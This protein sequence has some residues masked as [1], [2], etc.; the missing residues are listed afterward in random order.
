MHDPARTPDNHPPPRG[1][2]CLPA[3]LDAPGP[4]AVLQHPTLKAHHKLLWL[5]LATAA[6]ESGATL[7]ADI[8]ASAA[9]L[10]TR[11]GENDRNVRRWLADLV[12]AGLVEL[13]DRQPGRNSHLVV[14]DPV[15][16][17]PGWQVRTPDPQLELFDGQGPEPTDSEPSGLRLAGLT[18]S[19]RSFL[20]P[21]MTG[22][23]TDLVPKMTGG[24]DAHSSISAH[25]PFLVVV[26][27]LN[28]NNNEAFIRSHHGE[29]LDLAI[30][31]QKTIL[32]K[33]RPPDRSDRELLIRCAYLAM[34]HWGEHWLRAAARAR[35][36]DKPPREPLAFFRAAAA[37]HAYEH[38]TCE[39]AEGK[40]DR[41]A[42]K[43]GFADVLRQIKLPPEVDAAAWAKRANP[44]PPKA[45]CETPPDEPCETLL[46]MKKRLSKEQE[47]QNQ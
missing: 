33:K 23:R 27:E 22:G 29:L 2:A 44:S 45:I 30:E 19:T 32:G 5:L 43:K 36:V 17:V 40:E 25:A 37:Y 14:L 35:P 24:C 13:I 26:N 1:L 34:Q 38:L 6:A 10:A 8:L 28:N 7:P 12:D 41:Q 47:E 9:G 39:R 3:A 46:D 20:V 18:E 31:T 11:L 42:A 16:A 21:K 4:A 15:E